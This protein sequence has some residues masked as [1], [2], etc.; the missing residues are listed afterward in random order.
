MLTLRRTVL[1]AAIAALPS[2]ATA[3]GDGW[4]EDYDEAVKIAKKEG[5]D[6]FVDFTGSGWCGWCTRLHEEVFSRDAFLEAAKKNYVLV[7]L[8]YQRSGQ[9]KADAPNPKRNDELREKYK[10]AGYPTVLLMDV[11]GAVFGRTGYQAGGP[12]KYVAHMA[13]LRSAG[14]QELKKIA[15]VV[16]AWSQAEGGAKMAALETVMATMSKMTPDTPGLS[17][18]V[19]PV[20]TA[21]TLDPDNAKGLKLKAIKTLMAAGQMDADV[22]AAGREVDPKNADGLLEQIVLADCESITKESQVKPACKSIAELDALGPIKDPTI[23]FKLYAVAADWND[24]FVGD[25]AAAKAFATKAKAVGGGDKR[26]LERMD[27]ILDS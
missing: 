7:A 26:L 24:R 19:P 22:K 8:D 23:A 25:S 11:D 16:T 6:L 3:G 10:I 1:L 20:K 12:E 13:E 21:F 15:A 17:R 14:K 4:V 2:L 27:A 5:K 18:L 9:S